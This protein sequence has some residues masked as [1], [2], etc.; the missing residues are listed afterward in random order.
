MSD[1]YEIDL[2][3]IK[4]VKSGDAIAIRYE[5]NGAQAIHVI[6]G[7]YSDTGKSM[8]EHINA[9]YGNPARIDH[10]VVTHPDGDH[11]AGLTEI[12]EEFEVGTLWM[13]RPWLYADQL[14]GRFS[15]FTSVEN[16]QQRLKEIYPNIA[17]LEELALKKGVAIEAPFQGSQIGEF[18]VLAPSP[19]RF[20]DLVVESDKTPEAVQENAAAT[21]AEVL[22]K[23]AAK[24][25][26][27]VKAAWGAEVFP[28]SGTTAENE[29]SVVQ[30]AKL[31][32]E[33]I[34]FTGDAG[35]DAMLE[36][37]DYAPFAGLVLPGVNRFQVP[38]H[39]SRHNVSTAVLDRWLGSVLS[40]KPVEGSE[41]FTAAVSA[42]K[43]DKD[44]PRKA[45]LRGVIHRGAE[46]H[47]N[48][49]GTLCMK[50]GSA[51]ARNWGSAVR[52]PY[53]ED[54]EEA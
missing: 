19:S 14:I 28:E 27:L 48:E 2:L 17:A 22:A 12:L 35:R 8:V 29:M 38:H 54:Q 34:V 44:H 37:A 32:G 23:L 30:H 39:G 10:V 25:V 20:F 13:L 24:A 50:G 53:P 26:N 46:V 42:S 41:P 51:P 43:D 9:Y 31:N 45:V 6:D 52:L 36:A 40:A 18:T 11:A 16:L 33:S 15:R 1:F 4:S 3:E 7:G 49:T 5:V 21:F 47:S